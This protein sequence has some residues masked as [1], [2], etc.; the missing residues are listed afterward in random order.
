MGKK[1]IKKKLPLRKRLVWGYLLCMFTLFPVFCTDGY[2]NIRHDRYYFFLFLSLVTLCLYGVLRVL[3]GGDNRGLPQNLQAVHARRTGPWYRRLSFGDWSM[4]VLVVAAGISTVLSKYPMDALLGTQ[5]RNNGLILLL[6]YGGVYFLITRWTVSSEGIFRGLGITSGLVSLVTLLN[7]FGLDPLQML[8][9]L[10]ARDQNIF[11]STIGN[12]NFLSGYLCITVPAMSTLFIH[13]QRKGDRVLY[14]IWAVVGFSALMC[15]DSDSGLLGMGA[16]CLLELMVYIREPGKLKRLLLV[17]SS[18]LLGA[19]AVFSAT[20]A[21]KLDSRG[22]G[23]IQSWLLFSWDTTAVLVGMVVLTVVLYLI[24]RSK[25]ELRLPGVVQLLT[26][27]VVTAGVAAVVSAMIYYTVLA[28]QQPLEES[29]SILRLDDAWGTNRGFMWRRSIEI[30]REASWKDKLLGTG[31]DTFYAAFAPYFQELAQYGDS[32]TNAAHNEYIH[33]LITQGLAGL[34]AYLAVLIA[35]I[36]NA[37]RCGKKDPSYLVVLSG[38]I[39][40]AAQAMVNVAQ[41]ITTPLFIISL[42]L[43]ARKLPDKK[44]KAPYVL[45]KQKK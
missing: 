14:L 28:P 9:E 8:G 4:L 40:Y 45:H 33:Y 3:G 13:A 39:A 27:A 1:K 44:K 36:A 15:A 5:G 12:K 22:L 29:W 19:K 32:S 18:M 42:S 34:G 24:H 7:F 2:F 31:P 6:V 10:S 23:S 26:V 43:A 16:F 37:L 35:G 25:P 30:F 41:P 21:L 17:L 38:V 20:N 11:I